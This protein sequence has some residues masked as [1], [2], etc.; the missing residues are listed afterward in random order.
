MKK[1]NFLRLVSMALLMLGVTTAL[2]AQEVRSF[3]FNHEGK[4]GV[5]L[6]N[7]TRGNVAIEYN[8]DE[9]S[10]TSFTYEGE[11][12][13]SIGIADISLPNEK[14]LPNVPSYSRIIA[15]PQGSQAVLHVVNYEQQVIDNVNV[16]PSLGVQVENEEPD[17][18]YTKDMKVYSENAF[19]PAEFAYVSEPSNIRGVDVV[20]LNINPVRF[21]PVTKQAIVYHNIEVEVEFVGGNGQF[22]DNRLRSRYYD[23][24]LAQ[25]ILNYNSLPVIDYEARMQEWL[26]NRDYG[27]EYLIIIPNNDGFEEPANRLKE[28]RMQ[29]GILTEV[30]R[31][32]EIPATTTAMMKTWFHNAYN[33]WDIPPVAVLLFADHNTNMGQGIPA[34]EIY[35]SS[36]YG[37]CITDNQYADVT[38]DKLPEMI[39]SRLIAA[40]PTEAA[41]MADKQI[42]YEFTNPNMNAAA[43]NVPITALGWQTERWFQLCSEVV[44]GYFRAHGKNPQRVN[45]IYQGTP[46]STWSSN[47]NTSQVVGYFGPSG[48]NYIPQTPSELGGW[49]GGTP[50]QIVTAINQGTMLVQHRDH[51]LETG[52]GEPAFRNSHVAQLTNVG[53]MPFVFSINCLTGQFDLASGPCFAEAFMRH[54]Y[55]GQNAGAV[56]LICP[57]DVSYSFVNDALVW[58]IYDHFQPDFMP[59][60]GPYAVNEGNWLPAFGLAAGKYFLAASSWPYN[61]DSKIITYQMFTAHCDAFLR[62]YTEV[63]QTITANHQSVQ[64]AGLNTFQITAPE[65]TMIA[66]T[67]GEGENLE[68]VAVAEA[69]GSVQNLEIEPQV[70]PTML[71]LTITGQNYLR[72]ETDIEVIP[73]S[74]PYIIIDSY[75]LLDGAPQINFGDETG[76]NIHLKNVGNSQAPAGSMTISTE[77]EYVTIT[78]GTA[79]FSAINS[80]SLHNLNNAFSFTVADNV[81]D[82][83]NID[84]LVTITSGSD[85]YESHITMKAYAPDFEIHEVSIRELQNGNGNGRLDPGETVRL[86]IPVKNNGNADSHVTYATIT[87]NNPFLELL[88]DPTVSLESVAANGYGYFDFE[89]LVGNAPAGYAAAYS[90]SVASGVYTDTKDFMSKIGLNVEDFESGTLDPTKWTNSNSQSPWA[91]CTDEPYEGN[92]CVKSGNIG[93]NAETMLSLTYEVSATDSI[94]FYYKVSSESGWDKLFFYI[95]NQEKE[96][97]SGNV[98]WTRAQYVVTAGTHTFKWKYKKDSSQT[99]GSDCAWIDFVILPVDRNLAVSAGSD[100]SICTDEAAQLNGFVANQTSLQWT[101]AGDGT[102]DDATSVTAIY[103]PGTQDIAN[104]GTTLTLTAHKNSEVLSDDVVL[105]FVDEPVATGTEPLT[106]MA[107]EPFEVEVSIE[108]LG[109]FTG[110]TTSGTGTFAN[111]TALHTTYTPSAADYD[112]HDIVLT[113]EYTGCGYKTYQF[114][115]NVHFAQDNVENLNEAQMNIHPNPTNDVI[116]ITIDNVTSDINIVIY[117]NV[118]QM[119]YFKDDTSDNGYNATIDLGELSSGAYILQVRSDENVWTKKIIKR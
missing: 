104:G 9:L 116:N 18:N 109:V 6:K 83:T 27:W 2:T 28:Y 45:C 52:W 20:N 113:A 26:R 42:E 91:I 16:E 68:I 1:S 50:E 40:N 59:T 63:P 43:Y 98:A 8:I 112:L 53:K 64:L 44:G 92:Y 79:T 93:D 11:E 96:N 46:G 49:T 71:H 37:N 107:V 15:I 32:D 110:W 23:P 7:Q 108:N 85:T 73:A 33:T 118:G 66:L 72:Y 101:T 48:T 24:I 94:A 95:D 78:N 54:T 12:M 62:L 4:T 74:G 76:F 38:G 19:Y 90:L 22:G 13:Q 100:I 5:Q 117:N 36:S 97:W 35:H 3:S 106:L 105:S 34:E 25:N 89:V 115:V 14:G 56:G 82:R 65:G 84:F 47:S 60:Y 29:Q 51:G 111:P 55:N 21:N 39:F 119:V 86:R 80:N 41:M 31:L 17:M 88:T 114:E 103:T 61:S 77:S 102:F 30:F 70:P 58:G 10:L 99:G 87:M 57:T 81:P 75:T 69:T 67:K